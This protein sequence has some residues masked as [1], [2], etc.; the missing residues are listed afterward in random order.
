MDN[1]K[2]VSI[3][4]DLD[5]PDSEI[6]RC[7]S[8]IDFIMNQQQEIERLKGECHKLEHH[9]RYLSNNFLNILDEGLNPL[10]YDQVVIDCKE[11]K[12][13]RPLPKAPEVG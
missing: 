1:I 9:R 6:D 10:A 4:V 11:W 7:G 5:V 12:D 13:Y 8:V 3:I 2:A